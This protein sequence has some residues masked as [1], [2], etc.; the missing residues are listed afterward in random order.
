MKQRAVIYARYSTKEQKEE[1]AKAQIEKCEA[2]AKLHDLTVV[3]IFKDEGISGRDLTRPGYLKMRAA[4]EEGEAD[5]LLIWDTSRLARTTWTLP[6][7]VAEL[8]LHDR[9]VLSCDGYDSR[10][11]SSTILG[12][13]KSAIDST[14]LDKLAKDTHRGLTSTAELGLHCGGKTYG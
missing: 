3:A 6:K 11:E 12:N 2:L 8:R 9:F 14:Y 10:T 1:S 7:M 4:L 5:C 13:V